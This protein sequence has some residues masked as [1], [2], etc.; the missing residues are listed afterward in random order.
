MPH[1]LYQN[2]TSPAA[3]GLSP[4][5]LETLTRFDATICLITDS[6]THPCKPSRPM[7]P[8]YFKLS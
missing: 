3:Q 7:T 1:R 5:F 6:L 4:T 2:S 8:I